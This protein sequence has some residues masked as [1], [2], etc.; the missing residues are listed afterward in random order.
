[1]SLTKYGL[2]P[3][4][5]GIIIGGAG[6]VGGVGGVGTGVSPPPPDNVTPRMIAISTISEIPIILNLCCFIF[7]PQPSSP[8]P[9]VWPWASGRIFPSEGLYLSESLT[10]I[11]G[12]LSL[13]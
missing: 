9:V 8:P 10:F 11:K 7:S 13:I 6:G 4:L 3:V 1:V 5:A 2:Y 12:V